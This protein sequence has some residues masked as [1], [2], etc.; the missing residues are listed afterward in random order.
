MPRVYHV[1]FTKEFEATV[2]AD[3]EEALRTALDMDDI[4]TNWDPPDNWDIA[5]HDTMRDKDLPEKLPEYDAAAVGKFI[6]NAGDTKATDIRQRA[7]AELT[8]RWQAMKQLP[9]P[10]EK[11]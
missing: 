8:S 2:L 7:E 4:N 1:T 6:Y 11:P 10:F 3:S 5:I 9:L